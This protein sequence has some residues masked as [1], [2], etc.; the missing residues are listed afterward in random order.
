MY[1][2]YYRTYFEYYRVYFKFYRMYFEYYWVYFKF[3]RMYFEFYWVY[4]EFY[5]MNFKFYWMNF[6]FY[7]VYF[8][9]F[10][11]VLNVF[12]CIEFSYNFYTFLYFEKIFS[13]FVN[14]LFDWRVLYYFCLGNFLFLIALSRWNCF[15]IVDDGGYVDSSPFFSPVPFLVILNIFS[16]FFFR[17]CTSDVFVGYWNI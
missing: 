8:E 16:R 9:C 13:I 17:E 1:F 4:F 5:R 6:K 7:W 14:Y 15:Y 2:E 10:V 12:L 11:N 3:Y